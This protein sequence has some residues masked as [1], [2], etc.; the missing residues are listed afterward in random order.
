MEDSN[1]YNIFRKFKD[2]SNLVFDYE[3]N[4]VTLIEELNGKIEKIRIY[5]KSSFTNY[6]KI[7]WFY[8]L[9]EFYFKSFWDSLEITQQSN[10]FVVKKTKANFMKRLVSKKKRRFQNEFFD[11]DL[12]YITRRVIAMGYPST[13]C[14]SLYR[15]SLG[16]VLHFLRSNHKELKVNIDLNKLGI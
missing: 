7:N 15:N 16:D 11:L 13:G 9:D 1:N 4:E 14:E 12:S 2:K 3:I 6:S 5:G 8:I 10:E